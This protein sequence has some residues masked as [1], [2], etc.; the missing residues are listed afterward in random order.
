MTTSKQRTFIPF[1]SSTLSEIIPP[2]ILRLLTLVYYGSMVLVLMFGI[3]YYQD[4]SYSGQG[5]PQIKRAIMAIVIIF[6][7]YW[8]VIYIIA[9]I[10][11][12]LFIG[13]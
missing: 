9:R 10:L 2:F 13:R 1:L 4:M 8:I 11:R 12:W 5:E 3:Q 7:S 6:I